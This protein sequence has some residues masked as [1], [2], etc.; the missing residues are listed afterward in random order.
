M[1]QKY[2]RSHHSKIKYAREKCMDP[3][4][5]IMMKGNS[6]KTNQYTGLWLRYMLNHHHYWKLLLIYNCRSKHDSSFSLS[7]PYWAGI[8][9]RYKIVHL[10]FRTESMKW[11]IVPRKLNF[12]ILLHFCKCVLFCCVMFAHGRVTQ[13]SLSSISTRLDLLGVLVIKLV[14]LM[15]PTKI[16][17]NGP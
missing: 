17:S 14:L 7:Q 13:F 9:S 2:D 6:C 12:A 15:F 10:V 5:G 3:E 1:Q 11:Y 16:Q 8:D 4:G